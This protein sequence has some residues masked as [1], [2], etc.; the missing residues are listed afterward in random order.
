MCNKLF[1]IGLITL[2]CLTGCDRSKASTSRETA[3]Q[4][5]FVDQIV[6]TETN[7]QQEAS[8]LQSTFL[9]AQPTFLSPE[10][11]GT[12]TECN[13]KAIIDYSHTDE[14]YVMVQYTGSTQ[15]KLKAQV[16]G[17]DTTYTYNIKV[18]EWT[19]FPLSDGNGDYQIKVF[20]NI[21]GNRYALILSVTTN[22]E[23]KNEFAPFLYPN[24]Y[25]NF[26]NATQTI[27]TAAS[28]TQNKTD[29][30]SK[31]ESVYNYVV[32]NISYD[33]QKATTVKSGYLP[34]LDHVL[35]TQKGICFDYA[36]LMTGMLRSQGIPCKLVIGYAGSAYHAWISVWSEETG[37]V[38]G[39]VFFNGTTWQRMDPT[40]ASTSNSDSS[41]MEF[42]G[43]GT[44]YTE[45]Y[46]Y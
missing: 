16:K 26:E 38:D 45:K 46:I 15:S 23:L 43:D 28:L 22:V 1:L 7:I 3:S 31:V 18:K 6:I 34:D 10:A 35:S 37:W 32:D 27:A 20:E 17:P 25:V 40:F 9:P 29:L 21:S 4:E 13:A 36:S 14:G 39:A 33:T 19:V 24:Q 8:A 11:S 5:A 30:L 2:L 41:I 42:I 12:T 44:N